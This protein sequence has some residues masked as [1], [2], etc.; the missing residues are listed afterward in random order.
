MDLP[1]KAV[2]F[3]FVYKPTMAPFGFYG[4]DSGGRLHLEPVKAGSD[5]LPH[6]MKDEPSGRIV[7][8]VSPEDVP[9]DER[10]YKHDAVREYQFATE[11]KDNSK[12][13]RKYISVAKVH[14]TLDR[15]QGA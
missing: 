5:D 9:E 7:F 8:H 14:V 2:R 10:S 11:V 1:I 12:F 4:Y 6:L 13:I 15:V 3:I